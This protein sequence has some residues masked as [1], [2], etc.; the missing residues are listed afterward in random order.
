M[1]RFNGWIV[2]L[3]CA[4]QPERFG[5]AIARLT[6]G[7]SLCWTD[8]RRGRRG[9]SI[10]EYVA[11]ALARERARAGPDLSV[12][13]DLLVALDAPLGWPAA[14]GPALASHRAGEC[15][16]W[17][18]NQLFRR[19]TDDVIRE[20]LGLRPLE[21]GAD[22]I[23]RAAVEALRVLGEL[24]RLLEADLELPTSSRFFV[25]DRAEAS[26]RAGRSAA[27]EVYPAAVLTALGLPSRM[28]K[29]PD[30]EAVRARILSALEHRGYAELPPEMHATALAQPD[31][32]DAV[33]CICSALEFLQ[34]RV[35]EPEQDANLAQEG[36]AWVPDPDV[37]RP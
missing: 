30:Q 2:G 9:E 6:P 4:A 17:G 16:D 31:V 14:L 8:A 26:R 32:L 34:R 24:R 12:G 21:V 37:E 23:A 7:A 15:L 18:P 36:W 27:I 13:G 11:A 10:A 1:S 19:H 3:D 5:V 25:A 33:L 20:Q 35:I 22:R 28:Y 29:R